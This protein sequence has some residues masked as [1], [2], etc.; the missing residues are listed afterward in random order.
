MIFI[1]EINFLWIVYINIQVILFL[2]HPDNLYLLIGVFKPCIL[3]IIDMLGIKSTTICFLFPLFL[4]SIFPLPALCFFGW[5]EHSNISFSIYHFNFNKI[6]FDNSFSGYL[7]D[8]VIG[9]SLLKNYLEIIFY[10]FN[11]NV[12]ILLPYTFLCSPITVIVVLFIASTYIENLVWQYI[13]VFNH[14]IKFK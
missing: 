12:E 5:F 13:F 2:I 7:R 1:F 10:H 6:I 9:S 3:N 8:Y 14:H 4:F 11:F